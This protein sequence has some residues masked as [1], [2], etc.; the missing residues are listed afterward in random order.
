MSADLKREL[1]KISPE[2][3]LKRYHA[4]IKII[5]KSAQ[6]DTTP[7]ELISWKMIKNGDK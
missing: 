5:S 1:E 7:D 2:I 4:L 6:V 3:K